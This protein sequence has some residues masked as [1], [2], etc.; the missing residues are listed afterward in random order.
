MEKRPVSAGTFC[1]CKVKKDVNNMAFDGITVSHLAKELSGVLTGGRITKI[2]Q[3]EKDELILTIKNNRETCRLLLSASASLPLAYLTS[4]N[5]PGPLTAPNFCMLLRKH[6]NSARILS[7]SQPDFER[8]LVFE[9]EHLNELGDLCTKYLIAELMG[10]HSN[11]IFCDSSYTII[12]SIKHI[13]SL[14]SSVR[15]VLPGRSYFIPKTARKISPLALTETY[16]QEEIMK[17]PLP[18]NKAIYTSLNG[19]SPLAA[20]E[21][22]HLAS[23]DGGQSTAS[24]SETEA[25]HLY[26]TLRRFTEDLAAARFQAGIVNDENGPVEF[27]SFPLTCYEGAGC[28]VTHYDSVSAMLEQYYAARSTVTRI[29]QK[30]VDLRKITSNALDRCIKKKELL[31]RQLKDTEKRDKYRIYGELLTTYGY[32][33]SQGDSSITVTNYYDQSQLTIPLDPQLSP[34]ENAKKYFDRYNKLKRTYEASQVQ[35]EECEKELE[36]LDSIATSLEIALAEEDLVQVKEE[37]TE[38][39]Y[40]RRKYPSGKNGRKPRITSRPFHYLSSDGYHMYV[41]KN[42]YQNEELTFRFASGGDWWFHAKGMAGSHVIVKN[43]GSGLLPDQ[44]YEEAGALAAYYSKGRTAP[45][46]E[47]DYTEK[48]NIRK[49][50]GGKPGFVVYYTNYSLLVSPDIS[51]IRQLDEKDADR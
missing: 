19:F 26:G 20:N 45:K 8:I 47:V 2:A 31:L 10:K 42:N 48:K 40:I 32:S 1:L 36:H 24:L 12:D 3:P 9:I 4:E 35:L 28:Q 34:M 11:L 37:L 6:L 41:G 46:V 21:V 44:T 51:G 15:E 49:P 13:S 18:L 33:A 38:A 25:L 23:L 27:A 16:F 5:K 14:V 17:K 29:R 43:T 22:C 30:S 39:G 7:V 50:G